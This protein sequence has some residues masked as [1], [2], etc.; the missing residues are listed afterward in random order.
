MEN[1]LFLFTLLFNAEYA[2]K[3]NQ[4]PSKAVVIKFEG[5]LI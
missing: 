5:A 4:T 2:G 3:K 1:K